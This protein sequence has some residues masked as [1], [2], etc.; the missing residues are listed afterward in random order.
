M[1][2]S[3][4]EESH[5]VYSSIRQSLGHVPRE[6]AFPNVTPAYGSL[7]KQYVE[8]TSVPP[9]AH[10]HWTQYYGPADWANNAEIHRLN[11]IHAQVFSF[12]HR[13]FHTLTLTPQVAD[14]DS[15]YRSDNTVR[16]DM[17]ANMVTISIDR[18]LRV[19]GMIST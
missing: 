18:W 17:E 15:K 8:R 2:L 11:S 19:P 13:Y 4:A 14:D 3:G 1:S 9:G 5:T 12:V 7:D 10:P 6:T 16:R